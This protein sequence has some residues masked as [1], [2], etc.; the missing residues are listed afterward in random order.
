MEDLRLLGQKCKN[1]SEK[2]TKRTEGMAQV[3]EHKQAQGS[4]FNP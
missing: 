1:L 3:V 2:A 4:E